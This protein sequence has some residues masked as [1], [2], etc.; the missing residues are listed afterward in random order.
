MIINAQILVGHVIV[1][2]HL[3]RF[4]SR[5]ASFVNR[6][7]VSGALIVSVPQ[8]LTN[9]MLRT[10]TPNA[11]IWDGRIS[12]V[13]FLAVCIKCG[14]LVTRSD[15]VSSSLSYECICHCLSSANN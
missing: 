6:L 14:L 3:R 13:F 12:D 7:Y 9:V 10:Q 5:V 15:S 8:F 11:S 1:G 4:A 2:A